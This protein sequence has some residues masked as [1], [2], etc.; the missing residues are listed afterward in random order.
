ME[1][2]N[3]GETALPRRVAK[4]I[5]NVEL[6]RDVQ[7]ARRLIQ[8]QRARGLPAS[9]RAIS[10]NL[11][12][13]AVEL[14]DVARGQIAHANLLHRAGRRTPEDLLRQHAVSVCACVLNR[15]TSNAVNAARAPLSCGM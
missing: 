10:T 11:P 5:E 7:G 8:Q 4:Q 6:V 2:H 14:A 3:R 15:T 1:D 9:T 13:T 12:L